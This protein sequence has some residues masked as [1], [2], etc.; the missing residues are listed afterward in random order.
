MHIQLEA[1]RNQA[2]QDL[3]LSAQ[4]TLALASAQNIVKRLQIALGAGT[5]EAQHLRESIRTLE[6]QHSK[7]SRQ[8][9]QTLQDLDDS[10]QK[11][12]IL[13]DG[14]KVLQRSRD[15]MRKKY[16]RATARRGEHTISQSPQASK[17][18]IK[19][20]VGTICPRARTLL[21]QLASQGVATQRM[22]T[23]IEAVSNAMGTAIEGSFSP[24]SASRIILEG[25]IEAKMQ[26]A[27]E[28]GQVERESFRLCD[29]HY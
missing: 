16:E 25:L 3:K 2:N 19:D 27:C 7:C 29:L 1:L 4:A 28:I 26:V 22:G 12:E 11:L 24:R 15:A 5:A 10:T 17:F 8:L 23:V 20:H 9:K 13:K 6:I 21:R 18:S 14:K